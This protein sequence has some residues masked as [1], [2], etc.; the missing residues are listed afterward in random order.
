MNLTIR[1]IPPIEIDIDQ[2]GSGRVAQMPKR[3]LG[4]DLAGVLAVKLI[5]LAAIYYLFFAAPPKIDPVLHL[6]PA[7][8]ASLSTR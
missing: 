5:A 2:R 6:A 8:T 7:P 1:R 4:I 3:R